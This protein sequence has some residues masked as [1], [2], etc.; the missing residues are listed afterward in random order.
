MLPRNFHDSIPGNASEATPTLHC[1]V[2]TETLPHNDPC[3]NGVKIHRLRVGI[4]CIARKEGSKWTREK[5]CCFFTAQEFWDWFHPLQRRDRPIWVWAHN[6]G[7]DLPII[8]FMGQCENNYLSV[9]RDRP[10][11]PNKKGELKPQKPWNGTVVTRDPPTIIQC[12]HVMGNTVTF[13]DLLNWLP[14]S[15][16]RVGNLVKHPKLPMPEFSQPDA[17]WVIYCRNDVQIL[18]AGVMSVF[19][20]VRRHNLGMLRW[21]LASQSLAAYRHRFRQ[22]KIRPHRDPEVTSHERQGYYGGRVEL[23]YLGKVG[24]AADGITNDPAVREARLDRKPNGPLHEYDVQ[25]MYGHVMATG[26]LPVQLIDW[27]PE[28]Q[29]SDAVIRSLGI[30]CCATVTITLNAKMYPV[31]TDDGIIYPVGNFVTTLAG[32]EL[33]QA[34]NAG[35]VTKVW[36]YS[37][38]EL[39]PVLKSFADYLLSVRFAPEG[40]YSEFDRKV[41]K[42]L[43]NSITGKFGQRQERWQT[44]PDYIAPEPWKQWVARCADTGKMRRYRSIGYVTQEQIEPQEPRWGFVAVSAWVTSYGR[45][46]LQKMIETAGAGNVIYVAT[47]SLIVTQNGR[48]NLEFA[49]MIR[50]NVPG[51]LRLLGWANEAE[52]AGLNWYRLDKYWKRAGVP[53]RAC[54]DRTG[55]LVWERFDGLSDGLYSPNR[56]TVETHEVGRTAPHGFRPGLVDDLG[57]V[58]PHALDDPHTLRPL[59]TTRGAGSLP[60]TSHGR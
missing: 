60:E 45:C 40:Q 17:D 14:M 1:F 10:H 23:M 3:R 42:L 39:Q 9:S 43:V 32:P 41:T 54:L 30:D 16:E 11:K 26:F 35:I 4:A 33:A 52:F 53:G 29:S 25:A 50:D 21:T 46:L 8:E 36:R 24:I 28:A 59:A 44:V 51:K 55:Q 20:Y 49:G 57:W 47:D 18:M 22:H 7:F 37:R 48:Q 12:K 2:D 56:G 34:L 31:R 6:W 13:I 15:L 38:Y 19:K 58:H 27:Q 5:W